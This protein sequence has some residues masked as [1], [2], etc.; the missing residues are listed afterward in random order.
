MPWNLDQLSNSEERTY[1][2]GLPQVSIIG[3]SHSGESSTELVHWSCE[4]KEAKFT[5]IIGLEHTSP[6][7]CPAD[8]EAVKKR[9]FCHWYLDTLPSEG[10]TEA[11]EALQDMLSFY[12]ERPKAPALFPISRQFEVA[13]GERRE[14]AGFLISSEE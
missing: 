2:G 6:T 4:A 12:S 13:S 8:Q 10:L 14:S 7:L 5:H 9:L 3:I 1:G 11:K